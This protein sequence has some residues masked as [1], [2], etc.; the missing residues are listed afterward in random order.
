MHNCTLVCGIGRVNR[1]GEAGQPVDA[2]HED[3]AQPAVLQVGQAG[4]PE[5]GPFALAQPQPEQLLVP[6]EIHA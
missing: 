4:Q 1:F 6:C 5:L 2:G 3:V